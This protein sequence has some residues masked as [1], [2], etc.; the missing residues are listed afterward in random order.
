MLF[1]LNFKSEQMIAPER[2]Q[3]SLTMMRKMERGTY[4]KKSIGYVIRVTNQQILL[5]KAGKQ[6]RLEPKS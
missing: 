3:C 4:L 1:Y 5:N 6:S 2:L